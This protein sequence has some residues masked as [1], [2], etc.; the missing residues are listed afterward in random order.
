M[1]EVAIMNPTDFFVLSAGEGYDISNF[2]PVPDN[3]F[4]FE[5]VPQVDLLQYCDIMITH[6]GMNTITEC[7]FCEVPMLI[8]PLSPFWDQPG[9]SA[10]A[11]FHGLG[12]RGKIDK[13]SAKTISKKLNQIKSNYDFYKKNVKTMMRKFEEK[14]NSAEAIEIIGKI[15]NKNKQK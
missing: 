6:G 4:V 1:I 3:L 13:D 15:I 11:V 10:R 5:F 9:N 8:Y 14:N 7:V 2:Y 12:L